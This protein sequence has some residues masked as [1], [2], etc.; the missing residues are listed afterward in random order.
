[1]LHKSEGAHRALVRCFGPDGLDCAPLPCPAATPADLPRV[2]Q[3][4]LSALE[5]S[6]QEELVCCAWTWLSL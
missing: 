6:F 3:L 2:D 1:M 4:P 5:P